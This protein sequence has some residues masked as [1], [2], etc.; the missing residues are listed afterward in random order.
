MNRIE[1]RGIIGSVYVKD[2]VNAKVAKF[3]IAT[4][5]CY[6]GREGTP[7][8]DTTWF[9]IVARESEYIKNLYPLKNGSAVHVIGR[10]RMQRYTADDG[11][12]RSVF[13]VIASEVELMEK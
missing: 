6:K 12:E 11:T 9:R 4:N 5:Q 10:V 1:L 13:E 3:S 7:V 2:F 8:N